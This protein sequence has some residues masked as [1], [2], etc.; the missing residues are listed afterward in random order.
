MATTTEAALLKGGA[1]LIEPTRAES[2]LTPEKLTEEHKLIA[3]TTEQFVEQEV[4]P[5]LDQLEQ[6]DWTVARK[7]LKRCGELGLLVDPPQPGPDGRPG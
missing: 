1:W 4:V 5:V 6:H 2:V 3:Q 7:L